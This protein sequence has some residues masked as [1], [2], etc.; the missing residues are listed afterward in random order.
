MPLS[1][2]LLIDPFTRMWKSSVLH[3]NLAN[4]LSHIGFNPIIVRCHMAFS[5]FCTAMEY[6]NLSVDSSNLDKQKVCKE[7]IGNQNDLDQKV[8]YQY[9]Y[10]VP[11][12]NETLNS[13]DIG[14]QIDLNLDKTDLRKIALYETLIKFKKIDFNLESSHLRYYRNQLINTEISMRQASSLIEKYNPKYI[15]C[16]SPQYSITGAFAAAASERKIPVYF[17]EGSCSPVNKY[18]SLRIWDWQENGLV[19]PAKNRFE[20]N[21]SNKIRL[22]DILLARQHFKFIFN[23]KSYMVYSPK[24]TGK[25]IKFLDFNRRRIL[26]IVSSSDEAF[27]AYA[28]DRFPISKLEGVVF[29]NQFEWIRSLIAYARENDS[30]QLIIRIHPREYTDTRISMKSQA[31]DIWEALLQN[32]PSNVHVDLPSHKISLYDYIRNVSL[33]TTGWSSVAIEAAYLGIPVVTYDRNLPSFPSSIHVSGVTLE[34]YFHNLNN[35]KSQRSNIHIKWQAIRWIA[36]RDFASNIDLG[37]SITEIYSPILLS[38]FRA[39]IQKLGRLYPKLS[40]RLDIL[41]KPKRSAIHKLNL[42]LKISS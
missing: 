12:E 41:R 28:I 10:L 2:V 37:G 24:R 15:F 14:K 38:E 5:N 42:I 9:E 20:E 36:F 27:S 40:R 22:R 23:S 8:D 17:L 18:R 16:V 19:D 13:M 3:K 7:C 35:F 6:R 31:A 11:Q 34:E 33:V 39:L 26:A 30:I 21:N 4:S 25:D 32:L 1:N 29:E